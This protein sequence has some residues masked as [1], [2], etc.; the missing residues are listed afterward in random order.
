MLEKKIDAMAGMVL[1]DNESDFRLAK[2][3]LLQLMQEPAAEAGPV[4]QTSFDVEDEIRKILLEIGIPD[5]LSGHRYVMEAVRLVVADEEYIRSIT[6]LLYPSVAEK[7]DSTSSKVERAIRHCIEAAWDR[8]D[9]RVLDKYFGN[10]I[11]R[12]SGRPTVG[13][14]IARIANVV[15]QRQKEARRYA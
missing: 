2:S 13:E 11:D 15:A 1:A 3:R 14:F 8:G 5:R 9:L 10:T 7:F 6:K 12:Y 4:R